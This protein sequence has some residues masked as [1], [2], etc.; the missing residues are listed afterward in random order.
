MWILQR[1]EV[2]TGR[3]CFHKALSSDCW[4]IHVFPNSLDMLPVSVK[5]CSQNVHYYYQTYSRVLMT[6]SPV[7]V[8]IFH[9]HS[10]LPVRILKTLSV[11]AQITTF[12]RLSWR[13]ALIIINGQHY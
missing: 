6:I 13:H 1:G 8:H 7:F 12:F 5:T 2:T 11:R 10:I 9:F 4:P 3:I